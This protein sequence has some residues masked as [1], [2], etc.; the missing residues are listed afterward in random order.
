MTVSVFAAAKRLG[1]KSGWSLSNLEMQKLLYLAHMF[2]LGHHEEPLVSGLFE[3]WDYGPVHPSLYHRAKVF[4]SS[5][6]EN[7]FH[8]APDLDDGTEAELLDDAVEQLSHNRPGRL[9]AITHWDQGAWA[10]NYVPGERG[11][12]IPNE[13][14]L[15]EYKERVRRV[16]ANRENG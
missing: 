14:I 1:E 5:P 10:K 9:V 6:V 12:V 11:I 3:A 7:V 13:D 2:H 16:R 8:S 4:G 15:E